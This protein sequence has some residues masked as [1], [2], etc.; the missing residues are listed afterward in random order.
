M[1]DHRGI[2]WVV[3][4]AAVVLAACGESGSFSSADGQSPQGGGF[5]SGGGSGDGGADAAGDFGPDPTDDAEPGSPGP[6]AGGEGEGEGGEA[7]D[8]DGEDRGFND[9][10]SGCRTDE[11]CGR[12]YLCIA[13][14]CVFQGD[15]PP[16]TNVCGGLPEQRPSADPP[17]APGDRYVFLALPSTPAL[18]RIDV[19]TLAVDEVPLPSEALAVTTLPGRDIAVVLLGQGRAAV[20]GAEQGD[21]PLV[22]SLE[23]RHG[24]T[25]LAVSDATPH[26]V[27][28]A[29]H[30]A[31]GPQAM[32]PS[33]LSVIDLSEA[34]DLARVDPAVY[35]LSVGARP[36][37]VA[38]DDAGERLYVVTDD[39][40]SLTD[41]AGLRGDQILPPAPVHDDPVGSDPAVR[42]VLLTADGAYAVVLQPGEPT[43]RLVDLTTADEAM[44]MTLALDA[45]P[46]DVAFVPDPDGGASKRVV[47]VVGDASQA[48]LLDVP[49]DWLE[50][51]LVDVIDVETPVCQVSVAP[52]GGEAALFSAVG[53]IPAL[54]RLKLGEGVA[55]EG[56]LQVERL[57]ATILGV[58]WAADG[59]SAVALHPGRPGQPLFSMMTFADGFFSKSF[60]P[61]G[62]RGRFLFAPAIGGAPPE[63]GGGGDG[64][65]GDGEVRFLMTVTSPQDNRHELWSIPTSSF[66]PTAIRLRARPEEL[67]IITQTNQAYVTQDAPEGLISFITLAEGHETR[68]V[69]RFRRNRRID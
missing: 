69:S 38:F 45:P 14:R 12:G 31:G 44:P 40:I 9:A 52:G 23:V 28:W 42:R 11:D 35:H 32:N 39:G 68:E 24:L 41:I 36:R 67:G 49:G 47:A 48:V 59:S 56:R 19:L 46:T 3:G 22:T 6:A 50:G 62:G 26:V 54:V 10:P 60:A 29:D 57:A 58:D 16:P 33:E 55:E 20:V 17:P 30:D 53:Q 37:Q 18:A 51:G 66:I 15:E 61:E 27:A 63:G 8:E 13:G 4:L 5:G 7:A 21:E 43:L 2:L 34:D 64:G 65:P 25:H 1:T